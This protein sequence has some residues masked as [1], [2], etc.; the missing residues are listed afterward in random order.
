MTQNAKNKSRWSLLF[1][2]L[3]P[4]SASS[5]PLLIWT[6]KTFNFFCWKL[7]QSFVSHAR[8]RVKWKASL[9]YCAQ[10]EKFAIFCCTS[11][12]RV[13]RQGKKC[14]I[15]LD[16]WRCNKEN[17]NN[18]KT[19]LFIHLWFPNPRLKLIRQRTKNGKNIGQN[20]FS[21]D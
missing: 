15:I 5:L 10:W 2:T 20:M 16:W 19:H 9:A 8:G 7:F 11:Y 3:L 17:C 12:S 14:A 1:S 6:V 13:P 4:F 18:E 21:K